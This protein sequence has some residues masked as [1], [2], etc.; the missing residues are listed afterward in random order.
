ML[1]EDFYALVDASPGGS[2]RGEYR[3]SDKTCEDRPWRGWPRLAGGQVEQPAGKAWAAALPEGRKLA[4]RLLSSLGWIKDAAPFLPLKNEEWEDADTTQLVFAM[5]YFTQTGIADRDERQL[6]HAAELCAWLMKTARFGNYTRPQFR[7][8]MDR[9]VQLLPVLEPADAQKLIREQ[10]FKQTATLADLIS[11][12]G[13]LGQTAA[14]G[15]R[16][17]GAGSQSRHPAPHPRGAGG[18][19]RTNFQRTSPCW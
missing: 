14:Q 9:L 13:E 2:P 1:S 12:I 17:A 18:Q 15:H 8:A 10:L 6:Q 11:I 7:L 4:T 19:R 5:E 16:L 3:R